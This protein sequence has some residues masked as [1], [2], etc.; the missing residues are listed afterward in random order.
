[1]YKKSFYKKNKLSK[2]S[3]KENKI[4]EETYKKLEELKNFVVDFSIYYKI[5]S[6]NRISN[7]SDK[8]I[9]QLFDDLQWRTEKLKKVPPQP[10]P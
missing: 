3:V 8:K 2:Y 4:S 7:P 5:N 1:M 9:S 6:K 10:P